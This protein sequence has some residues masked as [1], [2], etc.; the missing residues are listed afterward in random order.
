MGTDIEGVLNT[1]PYN[2]HGR[3]FMSELMKRVKWDEATYT[4]ARQ[5]DGD[6][7]MIQYLG[8]IRYTM[9]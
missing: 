1:C 8:W 2:K 4:E 6:R 7:R 5:Y 3:K 9:V